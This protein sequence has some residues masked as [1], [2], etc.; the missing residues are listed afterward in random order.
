[1]NRRLH[2]VNLIWVKMVSDARGFQL[3]N[4]IPMKLE[5]AEEYFDS[6]T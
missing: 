3:Q 5:K 1:M 4:S 2:K 6:A